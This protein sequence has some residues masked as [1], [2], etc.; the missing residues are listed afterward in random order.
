MYL[1]EYKVSKGYIAGSSKPERTV[2]S[3]RSILF[4][5]FLRNRKP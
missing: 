2:F 1:G 4:F 3:Q 5:S